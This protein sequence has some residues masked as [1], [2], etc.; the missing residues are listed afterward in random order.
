M[1]GEA[2]AVYY[3]AYKLAYDVARKAERAYQIE[4]GDST[5]TYVRFGYWDSLRKGL[6]AGEKLALDLRRLDAAYLES[7]SEL[8]LTKLV[9]LAKHDPEKLL[10]LRETGTTKFKL[11]ENDFDRDYPTHY[12]RRLK[13]VSVSMPC[14]SGPYEGVLGTLTLTAGKTRLSPTAAL[15][16][17]YATIQSICTST[18]R[19]DGGKFEL[20]FREER[21]LPFEGVGAHV[22]AGDSDP[23]EFKLSGGNE[24]DYDTI[25]DLVLHLRYTARQGRADTYVAGAENRKRLFRLKHDFA[26]AWQTYQETAQPA[27]FSAVLTT[28]HFIKSRAEQLGNVVSV[29]VYTRGISSG[30]TVT[31]G[32]TG[33][34]SWSAPSPGT[35]WPAAGMLVKWSP[36]VTATPVDGTWTLSVS[37]TAKPTDVWLIFTYDV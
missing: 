35:A 21:L 1:V 19:E 16:P 9:S 36:S 25:S 37:G 33:V 8:E 20:Q 12:L 5:R 18:A 17:T 34:G 15:L 23:W 2:A 28:Q 24:L 10:E 30:E 32:K 27:T 6:L 4:R 14:V 7:K 31:L 11:V 26:D 29:H 22:A 13:Q 3:Q